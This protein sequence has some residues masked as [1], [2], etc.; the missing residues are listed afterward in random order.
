MHYNNNT[1]HQHNIN[2]ELINT[3]AAQRQNEEIEEQYIE[4]LHRGMNKGA[5]NPNE[6]FRAT[7]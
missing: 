4:W 6:V 7:Y 2:T 1:H 3:T 5:V